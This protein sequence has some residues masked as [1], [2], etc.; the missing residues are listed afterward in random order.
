MG[1]SPLSRSWGRICIKY[2]SFCHQH[3]VVALISH[4]DAIDH[5]DLQSESSVPYPF[6][7]VDRLTFRSTFGQWHLFDQL[8][9]QRDPEVG[10]ASN[11]SLFVIRI[12]IK[13][14]SVTS[15]WVTDPI[16]GVIGKTSLSR[17]SLGYSPPHGGLGGVPREEDFYSLALEISF[18]TEPQLAGH[19]INVFIIPHDQ[20]P[21]GDN[22]RSLFV[23][24][25]GTKIY[26]NGNGLPLVPLESL[27]PTS[28][29]QTLQTFQQLT[30]GGGHPQNPREWGHPKNK[31]LLNQKKWLIRLAPFKLCWI[32]FKPDTIQQRLRYIQHKANSCKTGKQFELVDWKVIKKPKLVVN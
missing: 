13:Y 7:S 25:A 4:I 14:Q 2:K 31:Q 15:G 10:F 6:G 19:G 20:T 17:W 3:R 28:Q 32:H 5:Y 30:V 12:C 26:N 29:L 11:I 22:K 9:R 1:V 23:G 18:D 24:L 21:T 8:G 27:Y 16:T